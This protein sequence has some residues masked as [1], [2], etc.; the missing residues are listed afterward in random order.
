MGFCVTD[1]SHPIEQVR[2][3]TKDFSVLKK[4]GKNLTKKE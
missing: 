3:S 4:W 1:M 2:Y